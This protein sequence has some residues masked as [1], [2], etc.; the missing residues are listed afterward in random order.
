MRRGSNVDIIRDGEGGVFCGICL[1][2]DYCAEHEWGI[3]DIRRSFGV[4]DSAIGIDRRLIKTLPPTELVSDVYSDAFYSDALIYGERK[5]KNSTDY[6]IVFD[7]MSSIKYVIEKDHTLNLY[8]SKEECVSD[9]LACAWDEGSFGIRVDE[10]YRAELLEL[11]EAFLR[12]DVCIFHGGGG[13]FR[14]AGLMMCIASRIPEYGKQEWLRGD[15]DRIALEKASVDTGIEEKLRKAGKRWFALSPRWSSVIRGLT[16]SYPVV[17]WLN[18]MEQ[19]KYDSNWF[20]VEDLLLW[21]KDKGP[22]VKVRS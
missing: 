3:K 9:H 18:P 11:Y 16:T 15:Q 12:K 6:F 4:D 14:N 7:S 1:G 2:A 8:R 13:V 17:Y 19:D 20:T 5:E 22:V 10:T 21:A